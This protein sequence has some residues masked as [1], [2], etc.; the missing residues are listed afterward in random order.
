MNEAEI[1]NKYLEHYMVE[2]ERFDMS[3]FIL[4]NKNLV[5]NGAIILITPNQ[6]V[7]TRNNPK[8]GGEIGSGSHDDTYDILNKVLYDLPLNNRIFKIDSKELEEALERSFQIKY[9]QNILI[10]MINEGKGVIHMRGIYVELPSSITASQLEFLIYLEEQYGIILK[11]I[12]NEMV[13]AGETPLILFKNKE[14]Q[15]VLCNSFEPLIEYARNNLVDKEKEVIEEKHIIGTTIIDIK[16]RDK[17][18]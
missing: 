2:N 4:S 12:S 18:I 14:R 11:Y 8:E 16:S 9:K 17:Q 6:I 3:K 13:K 1:R 15:N 5:D 10:R 7:F